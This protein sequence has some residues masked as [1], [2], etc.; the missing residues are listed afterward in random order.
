MKRKL[1]VSTTSAETKSGAVLKA[2]FLSYLVTAGLLLI[3]SFIMFKLDPPETI[4][5]AG[6]ILTY[7]ISCFVG[8]FIMGKHTERYRFLWGLVIGVIYFVLL[9]LISLLL[10]HLILSRLPGIL[11]V[12]LMCAL[13]GTLG[14]MLS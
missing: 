9:F 11:L 5:R 14:G 2:V 8:G 13:G 10:G 12:L 1:S 4:A 6:V 3:V 7:I